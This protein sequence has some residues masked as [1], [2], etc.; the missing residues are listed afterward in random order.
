MCPADNNVET[1]IE[2]STAT[3]TSARGTRLYSQPGL[4]TGGSPVNANTANSVNNLGQRFDEDVNLPLVKVVVLG[5]PGVGK[6]SVVK[7]NKTYVCYSDQI[8]TQG[9]LQRKEY[10]QLGAP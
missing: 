7:V 2:P 3:M 1:A 4:H 9:V 6:T 8:G 5:A 10:Q